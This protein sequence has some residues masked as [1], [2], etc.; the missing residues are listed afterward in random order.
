MTGCFYFTGFLLKRLFVLQ[1]SKL[2]E[3]RLAAEVERTRLAEEEAAAAA[4]AKVILIAGKSYSLH[5]IT[6][7]KT[8]EPSKPG[9]PRLSG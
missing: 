9:A 7:G 3:D 8:S 6:I 1:A 2:F 5:R 4:E